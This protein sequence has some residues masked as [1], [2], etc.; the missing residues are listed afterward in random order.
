MPPRVRDADASRR[1]ILAAA[2]AEFAA[3][4][5]A[6]AR[7]DR[8]A[9]EAASAKERI[10]AYFGNKDALFD[11]VFTETIR[12]ILDAV[13]FDATDL[14][15][16]AGRMF[17]YF[18]DH[19]EAQRLTTWYRLERPA[20]RALAAVVD[21][22][23]TRLEAL[24]AARVTT[25]FSPVE[26]LTLIQ[27]MASAWGT[28]NPEFAEAAAASDRPARRRA[29]VVAVTRLLSTPDSAAPAG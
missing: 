6:G 8:V 25:D 20:G 16:Y 13:H 29:V 24:A 26:L 14:P 23:R 11:A 17:D 21:A 18:A 9:A 2:T 22:N 19:P 12:Q 28:M 15:G 3:H 1:R 10:Y 5:I 7:M 27:A 4:G